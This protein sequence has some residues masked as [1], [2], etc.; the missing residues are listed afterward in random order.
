M[1]RYES[2][3]DR[4]VDQ[5]VHKWVSATCAQQ[6]SGTDTVRKKLGPYIVI[7]RETGAGGS[8]IA[9]RVGQK[10]GWDVLDEEI[11]DH[12]ATEYGTPP[13]LVRIVDERYVHWVEEMFEM[14]TQGQGLSQTTYIHRL[15]HLFFLAARRGNVVIV[16]RGAQFILPRSCGLSVRIVAPL[17][18][19][20]EQVLLR[21]GLSAKKAREF[22][23]DSDRQREAFIK[24]SFRR[25]V[26]DPHLHDL[27]I[28]V[29]KLVQEDAADLIVAA[30][31]SFREQLSSDHAR[32][33][34]RTCGR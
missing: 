21:R 17:D 31:Q 6:P 10:L 9:K 34:G 3:V 7:S 33:P 13:K 8:Q 24:R 19:R 11:L 26:T 12:L 20:V 5:N 1:A 29:E 4:L 16:G 15:S 23:E 2:A 30:A 27:V 25:Q 32:G 22:V 14:W 28:N 18:F